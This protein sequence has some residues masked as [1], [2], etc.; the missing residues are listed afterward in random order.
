MKSRAP[1]ALLF[2]PLA[3]LSVCLLLFNDHYLKTVWPSVVSGKLSDFAGVFLTPLVAFS[4]FELAAARVSK[5]SIDPRLQNRVLAA[6]AFATAL[7]FA[8][9]EVWPPAD[10]AYRYG[11]GALR[12]PFRA[13]VSLVST[14]S[15]GDLRPVI[16]TADASDLLAVPMAFVAYRFAALPESK[17]TPR[18][19]PLPSRAALVAAAL[20]APARPCAADPAPSDAS[21]SRVLGA[22]KQTAHRHDGLFADAAIGGGLLYV[23]SAASVSNGFRQSIASSATGAMAPVLS[24][25]LG[26]TFRFWPGLVFGARV[27]VGGAYGPAISTLGQRFSVYNHNLELI[28][29]NL[30]LRYYPDPTEGLHFGGG[31][32]ILNLQASEGEQTFSTTLRI[33]EEQ[34]GFGFMLEGGHGIWLAKQFSVAATLQIVAG[35]VTGDHGA[36]FVFA[37]Q[38]F[39]GVTW[40]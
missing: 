9:P 22:R 30:F 16:A 10:H 7:G 36:S 11:M 39:A 17:T 5:R 3:V 23:D 34:R 2:H 37:P 13:I 33:G 12:F 32:G 29:G 6:M 4:A 20:V 18:R 1:G 25:A 40:H 26:G 21:G 8:L 27:S 35:R 14:G 15:W 28:Q 24:F 38:L 19:A 31:A